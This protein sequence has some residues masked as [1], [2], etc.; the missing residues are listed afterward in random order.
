MTQQYLTVDGIYKE[1][2]ITTDSD[3]IPLGSF[4]VLIT[5]LNPL[6]DLH[7][8]EEKLKD[9]PHLPQEELSP[10]SINH[11]GITK[12]ELEILHGGTKG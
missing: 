5:F 10:L 6:E 8:D 11:V 12:R 9:I 7:L 1:G 3:L 4:H 2:R